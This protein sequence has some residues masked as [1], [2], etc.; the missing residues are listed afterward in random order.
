[1]KHYLRLSSLL[2]I[3][4]VA[5]CATP[6]KNLQQQSLS[7]SVYRYQPEFDRVLYR[8]IV[9]GRFIFKKF[10]LSGVLFFKQ[11]ENGTKRAIFQNEMGV[12]FFDMEWDSTGN[13]KVKQVMP[14]LDKEAV[15]KTLQKDMEMLMMIGMDKKSEILLTT[16]GGKQQLHRLNRKDGGYVYHTVTA[17]S[18][19]KIEN[20]NNRKR[21]VTV[22]ISG[23]ESMKSMPGSVMYNH[24]KANFTISLTKI[25]RNVNE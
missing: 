12:A 25:E 18:L 23:K 22:N 8:C 6:Y 9:D 20:T 11:L 14:Q 17:D 5:S 19:I 1:M 7:G 21:I 10:H 13:F 3:L 24:H 15:I 16:D 4:F 2:A